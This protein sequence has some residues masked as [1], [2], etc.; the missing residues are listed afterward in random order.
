MAWSLSFPI[1]EA[2]YVV[3]VGEVLLQSTQCVSFLLLTSLPPAARR[4]REVCPPLFWR[5][6][7]E[8]E[9]QSRVPATLQLSRPLNLHQNLCDLEQV[10]RP[11]CDL[12]QVGEP[13]RAS[14]FYHLQ[15]GGK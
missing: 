3:R 4:Q 10:T 5:G 9:T 14:V 12:E 1:H 7:F 15:N 8:P 6:S 13:V 2:G 11:L